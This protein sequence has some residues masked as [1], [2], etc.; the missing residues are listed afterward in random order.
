MSR[1]SFDFIG[2]LKAATWEEAKGKLRAMAALEGSG[3]S[4]EAV[5]P[6]RHERISDAVET[7]IRSFEDEGFQE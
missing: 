1:T 6:Y 5:R 4:G 7:F 2:T 3:S